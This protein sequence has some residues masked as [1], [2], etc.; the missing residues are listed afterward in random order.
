V[1]RSGTLG[2]AGLF[3]GGAA[4][5]GTLAMLVYHHWIAAGGLAAAG[6]VLYGVAYALIRRADPAVLKARSLESEKR[7]SA[8]G[9]ALGRASGGWDIDS[10][11]RP[12]KRRPPRR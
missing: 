1:L 9:R 3:A 5:I 6:V 11:P 10:R 2:I 4:V 7:L 12:G 8:M